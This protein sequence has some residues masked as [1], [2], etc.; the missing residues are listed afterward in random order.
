VHTMHTKY[1]PVDENVN[2]NKM[3]H[4]LSLQKRLVIMD[5]KAADNKISH[6][7]TWMIYYVSYY[8]LVT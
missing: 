6:F 2:H 8:L 7:L 1:A 3:P 4:V 5:E